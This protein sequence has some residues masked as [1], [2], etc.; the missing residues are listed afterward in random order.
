MSDELPSASSRR[1]AP[2]G[3]RLAV[4]TANVHGCHLTIIA[5]EGLAQHVAEAERD[6]QRASGVL[7][8]LLLDVTP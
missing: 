2:R 3:A 5:A 1:S 7:A 8:D 6:E 4:L